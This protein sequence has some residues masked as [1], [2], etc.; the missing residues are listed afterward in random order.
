MYKR[1]A[2]GLTIGIIGLGIAFIILDIRDIAEG[3]RLNWSYAVTNTVFISTV[4]VFTAFFAA[5]QF[6]RNG[7]PEMP[8]LAGA[9][10]SLAYSFLLYGWL[11]ADLGTRI[12]A[13]DTGV[14][15]ASVIFLTGT[16][17]SATGKDFADVK[18]WVKYLWLVIPCIGA[19]IIISVFTWLASRGTISFLDTS[20]G[21][22]GTRWFIRGIAEIIFLV[23]AVIFIILYLKSR[24]DTYYWQSL[25]LILLASGVFFASQGPMESGVV[26]WGRLAEY[27]A[28][29]FFFVSVLDF[30]QKSH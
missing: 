26:W 14:L 1:L 20:V 15:L 24:S 25:G 27:A 18:Q 17:F 30:H 23:A 28:C 2:L 7:P 9:A 22:M 10:I 29:G 8:G 16:I 12:V 21:G 4:G 6:I 13:H 19:I 11:A 5:R 3:Y